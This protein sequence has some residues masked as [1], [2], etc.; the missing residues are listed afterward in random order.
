MYR[1]FIMMELTRKADY[2]IRGMIYL[3]GLPEGQIALIGEIATGAQVPAAFLAK[4]L[5]HFVKA[6]LVISTRG[7]TGGFSLAKN[8]EQITLREIIETIEGPFTPNLCVMGAGVCSLSQTCPVH[9]VW[10]RIQSTVQGMLDEVTL[11]TMIKRK[12]ILDRLDPVQI[13]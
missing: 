8:P 4:I 2:A 13:Q 12:A 7:A 6:G 9:P 1:F 11:K 3:A 5:Q 10:R